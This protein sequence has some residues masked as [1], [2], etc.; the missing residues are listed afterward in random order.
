LYGV[1]RRLNEK[2]ALLPTKRTFGTVAVTRAFSLWCRKG[3]AFCERPCGL[4]RQR[5]EK[6]GTQNVDFAPPVKKFLRTPTP[7][8]GGHLKIMKFKDLKTD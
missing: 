1:K 8:R 7:M 5:P 4:H 6:Q 2:E 3:K